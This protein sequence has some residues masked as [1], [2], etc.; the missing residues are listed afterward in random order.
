MPRSAPGPNDGLILHQDFA[1]AGRMLRRQ[2][3]DQ[4]EDRALSA[5]AG[6]ENADELTLVGN[7]LNEEV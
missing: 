7:V 5:A 1:A 4:P 6:A 2:P 3:G